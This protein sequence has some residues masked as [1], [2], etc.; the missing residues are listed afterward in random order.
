MA[1]FDFN[2]VSEKLLSDGFHVRVIAG[3]AHIALVSGKSIRSYLF[4]LGPAK[5]LG[6]ALIKQ[7][8]EIENKTGKKFD[9]R[10]SD[11]PVPSP[12]NSENPP[13]NRQGK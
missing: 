1:D 6:R 2:S 7:V 9:M 10:L 4:P 5:A 8:E 13:E 11:E 3:V 12:L